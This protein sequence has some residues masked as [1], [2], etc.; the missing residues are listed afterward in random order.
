MNESGE[1]V[2]VLSRRAFWIIKAALAVLILALIG[3]SVYFYAEHIRHTDY[4]TN[5]RDFIDQ[6]KEVQ[7]ILA[8][9]T[10]CYEPRGAVLK[11]AVYKGNN[12]YK[13]KD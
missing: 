12:L 11:L 9:Q 1:H 8:A 3:I 2:I 13:V 5:R 6:H 10:F 4:L 7:Y